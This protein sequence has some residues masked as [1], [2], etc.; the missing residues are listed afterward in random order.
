M[1]DRADVL[2]AGTL[3]PTIG[4]IAATI[5]DHADGLE[6]RSMRVALVN[7][8]RARRARPGRASLENAWAGVVDAGRVFGAARRSGAP[9]V[10]VHTVGSP[11]LPVLRAIALAAAARLARRRVVVHL[12]GYDIEATAASGGRAYVVGLRAL[13]R[14][15]TVVVALHEPV[16]GVVRRLAPRARVEVLPNCVDCNRYRPAAP[17]PGDVRAVFVGTVGRR[18]GVPELLDAIDKLTVPLVCDVV[19]G[20]GEESGDGSYD[21]LVARAAPLVAE[22]RVVLHGELDR[23]GA[24][25][26]LRSASLFV[27]PSHAEGMPVALLEAMACGLPVVVTEAGAMGDVVRAAGC[28]DVVPAGD[29]ARLADALASLAADPDE[30]HRLGEAARRAVEDGYCC[31]RVLDDLAARYRAVAD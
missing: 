15:A 25:A 9:V 2:I 30:R 5:A 14:L 11:L 28:G 4:G 24:L 12:H 18:K 6:R 8:G 21:E 1:S 3:P 29:A 20:A 23:D 19:G 27:L 13:A 22:G 10:A 31:D 7:T 26:V 16:A 17:A